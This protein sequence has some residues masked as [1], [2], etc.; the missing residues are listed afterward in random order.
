MYLKE[1]RKIMKIFGLNSQLVSRYL[2]LVTSN[3][4]GFEPA[5]LL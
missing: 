2:N 5:C 1:M 4:L 3:V